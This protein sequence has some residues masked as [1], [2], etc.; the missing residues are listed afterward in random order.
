MTCTADVKVDGCSFYGGLKKE[1]GY[2]LN[3]KEIKYKDDGIEGASTDEND[4]SMKIQYCDCLFL[5]H[6]SILPICA[7][8]F[9]L[10]SESVFKR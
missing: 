5:M 6:R 4:C 2:T 7:F 9:R 3:S 8:A 10:R 1:D